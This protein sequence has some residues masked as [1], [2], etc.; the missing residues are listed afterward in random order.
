MLILCPICKGS[1]IGKVGNNQYYCWDC[2]LEFTLQK[3]K[4][5]IFEVADDGTLLPYMCKE[6]TI[7]C[8]G[9]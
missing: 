8:G 7:I 4:I 1:S 9:S 5:I 6:D 2:F 3:N